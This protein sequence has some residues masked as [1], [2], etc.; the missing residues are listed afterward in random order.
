MG[1]LCSIL[2]ESMARCDL[3]PED[4]LPGL[5][6]H[7][8][9]FRPAMNSAESFWSMQTDV[10]PY[11]S[12]RCFPRV[13]HF[14]DKKISFMSNRF[15]TRIFGRFWPR[16]YDPHCFDDEMPLGNDPKPTSFEPECDEWWYGI[17]FAR[18]FHLDEHLWLV[19]WARLGHSGSRLEGDGIPKDLNLSLKAWFKLLNEHYIPAISPDI[20][21]MVLTDH[22]TART[23]QGGREFRDGFLFSRGINWKPGVLTWADVRSAELDCLSPSTLPAAGP[24][25]VSPGI[26]GNP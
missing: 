8:F 21:I 4:V 14:E 26:M 3:F 13:N 12:S 18:Q 23:G 2:T 16:R 19:Q 11:P 5:D 10:L 7:E 9:D 22:G 6:M 17:Q 20:P 25:G 1:K 24:D 15:P